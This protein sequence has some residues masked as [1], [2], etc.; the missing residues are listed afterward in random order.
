MIFERSKK[1]SF[2]KSK[3]IF[4][5][6]IFLI[7]TI[8]SVVSF[9]SVEAAEDVCCEET[10]DGEF[11]VYTDEDNCKAGSS[12][13]SVTCDK[14][15]FCALGCCLDT[16]DGGCTD[17]VGKAN[18]ENTLD[19]I[20]Y[21]SF[22]CDK[23]GYCDKGCCE[24]GSNYRF[25]NKRS[26]EVL[27]EENFPFLDVED[28]WDSGISSEEDCIYQSVEEDEG[29]CVVEGEYGFDGDCDWTLRSACS[30]NGMEDA[31]GGDGFY[32]N[33]YC[34]HEDLK[35]DCVSNSYTACDGEDVYW[36]D[37]CGNREELVED[38]DYYLGNICKEEG[39]SASCE[40]VNCE[41][42]TDYLNNNHDPSMGGFRNNGESWCV[43]EGA[44]GP[45]LDLVGSRHYRVMCIDGEEMIEPCRDFREEFCYQVVDQN[46]TGFNL[47]KCMENEA[48]DCV[49][50]G[51]KKCCNNYNGCNWVGD[52]NGNC[53]PL[54]APGGIN[55]EYEGSSPKHDMNEICNAGDMECT[56]I[57]VKSSSGNWKCKQNCD[58][59]GT[60]WV[61]SMNEICNAM[62]D[63]GAQYNVAGVWTKKG[64]STSGKKVGKVSANKPFSF[65][66]VS[67]SIL[68]ISFAEFADFMSKHGEGQLKY[69]NWDWVSQ[70]EAIA[71]GVADALDFMDHWGG[72]GKFIKGVIAFVVGFVIGFWSMVLHGI[73]YN[74]IMT[75]WTAGKKRKHPVKL[76]CSPWVA[77]R[78][79]DDCGLCDELSVDGVCTEYKCRSLGKQCEM[80]NADD[81]LRADCIK[82]D[83]NDVIP[84]IITPWREIIQDQGYDIDVLGSNCG[85]YE[86]VPELE[87]L[88]RTTIGIK[89]DEYAK[90]RY[91]FNHTLNYYDM[92]H[93]FDQ[94][95]LS[96]EHNFTKIYPGGQEY[97]V[98]VR[99]IDKYD[100]GEDG[101]EYMIKFGTKEE[102]DYT[103]PII[104]DTSIP[105][106]GAVAYGLN[107]TP[108]V[109]FMNEPVETCRWSDQDI[110]FEQMAV[111]N[112]F[113][114]A[115]YDAE[116]NACTGILNPG[117]GGDL[118]EFVDGYGLFLEESFE[119]VGMLKGIEQDKEN[120]YYISCVDIEKED[121]SGCNINDN[122]EFE[123]QSTGPLKILSVEPENGTYYYPDFVL[124]VGTTGG[125]NN[126]D[127]TCYYNNGYGSLE[128][129]ETGGTMHVQEQ[130]VGKGDHEYFIECVDVIGNSDNETIKIEVDVD[131]WPPIVDNLYSEAGVLYLITDES[132][133]CEYSVDENFDIGEGYEMVGVMVETH[134]LVMVEDVYYIQCY[135]VF[136]NI[137]ELVVVY[138]V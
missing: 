31:S 47:A 63:C 36:F 118:C 70:G 29:C 41:D 86:I 138:N 24:I 88:T 125:V 15:N 85:G 23:V 58:C 68:T 105:N 89:T 64:Q 101:C 34:S 4:Q 62:G 82:G 42:T 39:E 135:D 128:F 35:C 87:P 69:A 40:S 121:K 108:L 44:T 18:C 28:V 10:I 84:P 107:E 32:A 100:N 129:F 71:K 21:G 60:D 51:T 92:W 90:C 2:L 110:A 38:C 132:S 66:V 74:G 91:D 1:F 13:A 59:R 25:V 104:L 115:C 7:Y 61:N 99:C 130:I 22:S 106:G 37:S 124:R 127:A 3:A 11:C 9:G 95:Y 14:T 111:N 30:T 49:K 97:N 136:E 126:G 8:I 96:L 81:L 79:G 53:I 19:S 67:G 93:S 133:T 48:S 54:V 119:C 80:I 98:F 103:A 72:I 109:L 102:P 56:W 46:G 114:C 116:S 12:R 75:G 76:D 77:P 45:G 122:Y 73:I 26:C 33:V 20:Y 55:I 78:G 137:G 65:Y 17:N 94:D 5:I 131:V 43:Y 117:V 112:S 50:C 6:Y 123:L 120:K 52:S 83:A 16:A 57:E 27:I 113:F 134:S